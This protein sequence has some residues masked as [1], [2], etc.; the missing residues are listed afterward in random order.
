MPNYWIQLPKFLPRELSKAHPSIT[1]GRGPGNDM[2]VEDLSISR[3]HARMT[4]KDGR[5]FLEDLGSRNG[6]VVNGLR[7]TGPHPVVPGDQ[8]LLGNVPLTLR[9][10]A[11][12]QIQLDDAGAAAP[13]VSMMCR[14]DQLRPGSRGGIQDPAARRWTDM[15]EI[16][17]GVSL[18]LLGELPLEEM[19]DRLLGHLFAFLKPDRGAVLLRRDGQLEPSV[20]RTAQGRDTLIRLSATMVE[21]AVERR[22][23]MLVNNPLLDQK[24]AQ[25]ASLVLSGAVSI[26]TVPL[27]H[28]GDVVG[29]IYLDAGP[30]RPSFTEDDLTFVAVMGHLAAAKIRQMRMAL[31]VAKKRDLDKELAVARQI[32]ERLLPSRMPDLPGYEILGI[33][34]SCKQISGDLFGFWPRPDGKLWVV[35]ADVS[36]KGVGPGLLMATFQA[37]M[38]AWSEGDLDSSH[39]AGR[40]SASIGQHTTPNRFITA[41]LMLLDPATGTMEA[42]NAGH[43]PVLLLRA[44]ASLELMESKGFPLA[45]FPGTPYGRDARVL[46]PGDLLVMV[47]DGILEAANAEGEEFEVAGLEAVLRAHREESLDS[48]ASQLWKTLDAYTGGAPLSDD[49]TLVMVRRARA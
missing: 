3:N 20:V 12:N 34:T 35:I 31:D 21:A 5:A 15:L 39:L 40:I 42:T 28:E 37:Y 22:E 33:N 36:G 4:W 14:V 10:E 27:E 19:L 30:Q 47:T 45:M 49:R 11:S 24:L 9:S 18:D 13:L 32:Q 1:L 23:A 41:F 48:L 26:M 16:L 43:N 44:D 29:L 46:E 2:V 17:H 6:V 8:V 38:Q 25:A 7:L